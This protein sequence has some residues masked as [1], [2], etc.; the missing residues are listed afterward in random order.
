[1]FLFRD[2][3]ERCLH[4][5]AA[6]V[7]GLLRVGARPAEASMVRWPFMADLTVLPVS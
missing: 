4:R 7:N 1:M 2:V 5:V 3:L 6:A